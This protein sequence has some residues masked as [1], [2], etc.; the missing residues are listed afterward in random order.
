MKKQ[1]YLLAICLCTVCM[2][3]A[4][5]KK[6]DLQL[7]GDLQF[8]RLST[9]AADADKPSTATTIYAA[10]SLST[11]INDDLVVGVTLLFNHTHSN[12]PGDVQIIGSDYSYGGN[13][14]IR[15]YKTV[16]GG[17]S[18]F[19][20]GDLEYMYQHQKNTYA[21]GGVIQ[22]ESRINSLVAG[23]YPGL[24]YAVSPRLMLQTGFANMLTAQFSHTSSEN[25]GVPDSKQDFFGVGTALGLHSLTVGFRWLVN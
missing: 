17:L 23:I 10:P 2:V 14:F 21:S 8:S 9:K 24:S 25:N 18:V 4:Q 16:A 12:N 15:R 1:F 19:L 22:F 13:V 5:I 7:G 11:A 6:G 3:H 20:E